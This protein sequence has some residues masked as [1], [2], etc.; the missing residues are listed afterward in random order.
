MELKE[1]N[2]IVDPGIGFGK[3]FK[4]NID[5]LN[6]L[7]IFHTLNCSIIL[8]F[9]EKFISS[10]SEDVPKMRVGGTISATIFALMQGIRI[11]RVHDKTSES[12]NKV[13][14]KLN[15]K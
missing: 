2:I 3:D 10:I 13:F 14:E 5:I 9:Q 1:K 8:R 7:S 6:N 4:Q 15:S 12:S 11:H